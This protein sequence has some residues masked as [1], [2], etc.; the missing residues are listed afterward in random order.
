MR[1]QPRATRRPRP[2]DVLHRS[3]YYA[4]STMLA[5]SAKLFCC[6]ILLLPCQLRLFTRL[7][8]VAV[9]VSVFWIP[10]T[11]VLFPTMILFTGR[12]NREPDLI[13]FGNFVYNEAE[14]R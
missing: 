10:I 13:R 4:L 3:V 5:M 14:A 12:T 2:T 7:G 1:R 11:L 6:G 9:L 8:A